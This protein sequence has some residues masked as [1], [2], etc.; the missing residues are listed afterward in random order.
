MAHVALPTLEEDVAVGALEERRRIHQVVHVQFV[1][2]PVP[3]RPAGQDF[4][5]E[6]AD[7]AAVVP[8]EV[9]EQFVLLLLVAVALVEFDGGGI[10][11]GEE[12]DAR[13]DLHGFFDDFV[14]E[15]GWDYH[16]LL[17]YELYGHGGGEVRLVLVVFVIDGGFV[18]KDTLKS[19]GV[20]WLVIG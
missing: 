5:A 7:D 9:L 20:S 19:H 10:V 6:L 14:W 1:L 15:W 8:D 16:G 2:V 12:V 17:L 18:W 3:V 13:G 11:V 4:S